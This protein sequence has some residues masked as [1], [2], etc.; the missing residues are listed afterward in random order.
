M[1]PHETEH[2]PEHPFKQTMEPP[3]EAASQMVD[4][5]SL[6][7][8]WLRI[9]QALQASG[10]ASEAVWTYFDARTPELV[11]RPVTVGGRAAAWFV[12]VGTF[13]AVLRQYRRGG[14]VAKLVQDRYVWSGLSQTRAF[15]EFDLLRSMW[16]AGLPVPRPL[17]AAVWRKGLTYRAALL[18]QRIPDAQPLVN[19]TDP[20]LWGRAG[21]TIAAMHRYGVWHADLNVFNILSDVQGKIWLIDFDRGRP[22]VLTPGKRADNLSRLLRSL[23][24]TARDFPQTCWQALLKGYQQV[25]CAQEQ[26]K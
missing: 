23:K 20:E 3:E 10:G 2:V 14:L 25:W 17:G 9:D 19:S 8:R 18:T 12:R 21:A 4:T 1:R 7:N 22:G 5:L 11:A 26:L 13:E 15:L 16:R 24:K 6:P